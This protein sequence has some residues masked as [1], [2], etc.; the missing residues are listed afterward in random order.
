M[1]VADEKLLLY[2]QLS[3]ADAE[4]VKWFEELAAAKNS[5]VRAEVLMRSVVGQS[6]E[7]S[8]AFLN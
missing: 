4:F 8:D 6:V 1:T 7:E 3:T 5:R 2:D